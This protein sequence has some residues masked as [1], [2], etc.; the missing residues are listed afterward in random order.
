MDLYLFDFDKTL[1]AYDFR[2]RLPELS[3]IT[4]ASQYHLAK[5][6]WAGGYERRAESGEWPTPDEY[7]AEFERVTGAA[8]TLRDYQESRKLASIPIPQSV[9]ALAHAA[10]LGTVSVLSNNPSP[11]AV[12]LPVLAPDVFAVVG[13]NVLVSSE[14]GVRKPKPEAYRLA[15]EHYGARA[16]DAFFADDSLEN[17]EGAREL[18]IT[19]HHLTYV[20]GVPQT[21]ALLGAIERFSQ[22]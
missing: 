18:G 1:Y 16:E 15:L 4:G 9:A 17:V 22:R 11:F 6:W 19:G 20:D 12:S 21:D 13:G 5:T 2:K 10:T 8:L 14:L 7:F 3:V